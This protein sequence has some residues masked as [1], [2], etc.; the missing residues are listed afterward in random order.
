MRKKSSTANP[1]AIRNVGAYPP[2]EGASGET[3][4]GRRLGTAVAVHGCRTGPVRRIRTGA[5]AFPR[6]SRCA[7]AARDPHMKR[8]L[9]LAVA[10]G[11]ALCIRGT[12]DVLAVA[13]PAPHVGAATARFEDGKL[14]LA[15]REAPFPL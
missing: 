14:W 6:G 7:A 13:P 1:H 2:R 12:S 4:G 8:H 15:A 11:L 5:T 9:G 10:L 3:S